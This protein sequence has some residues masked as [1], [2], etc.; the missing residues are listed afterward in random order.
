M[1][2]VNGGTE[3][4]LFSRADLKRLLIPL[5]LEQTLAVLIGI[6]DTVM[7]SSCGEAAVSGVSLVD[8]INVLLIQVFSALATGGAVLA[9]QYLG[10]R[11][12][13]NAGRAAKMLFYVVLLCAVVL[14]AV[15]L[16]LRSPMLSL[17]FGDIEAD[18]MQAAQVYFLL[19]ALSY[20]FL[21]MYNA[22]AALLRSMGNAKATLK[23]SLAMNIINVTGNALTIY[24]LGWGVFGAGLSTL[25]S[26]MVGAVAAQYA[27]RDPHASIPYP[28]LLQLEWNGGQ[29]RRILKVGVPS[30]LENAFFQLG[31]LLLV[32]LVST[33]G[34]AH[35]AANAVCSTISTFHCLPGS[36]ISLAMITVVGRC[37]GARAFDQARHY[38]RRLMKLTYLCMSVLNA[39]LLVIT[40]WM[41]SL[42]NLSAEA[43]RLAMICVCIHGTGCIVLWPMAF[44]FPNAL[45]A[46]GDAKYTM[47]VSAFSMV[48]FRVVF[49]FILA[50]GLGWGVVGVWSAMEIDW[51]F[52]ITMFVL[53]Y[54]SGKW[55]SKVL[56]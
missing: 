48:A 28:R 40:P 46:A 54:R 51:V 15:C 29:V 33:F 17:I 38:T 41:V 49:G 11:D 50:K 36:A 6:M 53:R 56:V 24:G 23:V 55:E 9:S 19:S 35:I 21:A 13:E 45:R 12:R 10:K 32:G 5:L 26:R 20:P 2:K 3:T 47:A 7:V 44:T 30:G 52:R 16:P 14:M 42:F 8:A 31:K 18:V 43:A 4:M 25:V 37:V 34:T 22:S 27:M 1:T 39:S